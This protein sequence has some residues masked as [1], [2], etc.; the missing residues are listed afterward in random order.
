MQDL[1]RNDLQGVAYYAI[2]VSSEGTDIAYR[3]SF[4]GNTIH[5]PDGSVHLEP[6]GNSGYTVGEMQ[7]DFSAQPQVGRALVGSYQDWA[8]AHRPGDV[9]S[10]QQAARLA[11]EL[12]RDGHH[13][14]DANYG[15]DKRNGVAI[16]TTGPD[17]DQTAKSR[18]NAYLTSDAGKTFVHEQDVAQVN[19]LVDKVSLQL[20]SASFYREASA[21][22]QA[23]I[24][25][26]TAK[27][28]NQGPKFFDEIASDIKNGKI[29]SLGDIN[30]RIDGFP[31]YMRSGRDDALRGAETYNALQR[32]G[33]HNAMH[34]PWQAVGADPLVSPVQ[35]GS[36]RTRPHLASQYATVKGAF[37]DP[38]QG[39]AVVE[40]LEQG[41]SYGRGDPN[42]SNSRGFYAQGTDLVQWDRDGHGRA[43]ISGQWSNFD[44]SQ[45]SLVHNGDHSLDLKITREGTASTL[46][47]VTPS[48]SSPAHAGQHPDATHAPHSEPHVLKDGSRGADVAALQTE[49][50]ERGYLPGKADGAY[51]R[52]TIEAVRAY[53]HDNG[54]AVDGLD[55][56]A[57]RRALLREPSQTSQTQLADAASA[58]SGHGDYWGAQVRAG[59]ELMRQRQASQAVQD[60]NRP[61]SGQVAKAC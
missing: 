39:R 58:T 56:P 28:Y 2:G 22:D 6:I 55:G 32:A 17:I 57:T 12:G 35:A 41:R 51:G 5:R 38:A 59:S 31:A 9:L 49:L 3:L 19:N 48:A 60:T 24:F 16:P 11:S 26:V 13:I 27:A 25:A 37:V 20:K 1:T 10:D 14:R 42:R 36:D 23:K 61:V 29:H 40:A 30:N 45:L 44:R 43:F 7:T 4:C 50:H 47:H 54:L 21:E 18:L 52:Q 15:S 46:L 53:Q 33:D 8:R 34:A